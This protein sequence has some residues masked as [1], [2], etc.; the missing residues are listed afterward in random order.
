MIITCVYKISNSINSRIYIGSAIDFRLRKNRHITHLNKNIHCNKKLQRFVNKYGINKL[1]FEIIERCDKSKLIETEQFYIN[2][3]NCIRNGFNILPTAGS[4]LNHKHSK[5]SILKQS[6]S[7]RGIKTTGMLNKK[8]TEETKNKIRLKATGRKQSTQTIQKRVKKNTGKK[9][10]ESANEIVRKK[11]SKL[12]DNQIREIRIL[13]KDGTRQ[14][15]IAK[16]FG[17]CQ[18]NISRIKQNIS[19][20]N[21]R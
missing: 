2:T 11:L 4:W 6:L 21:V 10:P 3:L 20:F 15:D 5:E 9:R 8:H 13:L 1:V 14:I 19:Y 12:S 18:R 7:K 17:V 16:K